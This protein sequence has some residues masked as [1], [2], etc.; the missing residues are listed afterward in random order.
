MTGAA[1]AG[2][3][4][5]PWH[6]LGD[7]LGEAFQ[8]ADD[9]RDALASSDEIGKPVGRD[10]V[11]GRPSAVQQHGVA[12]AALRLKQLIHGAVESIPDCPGAAQLRTLIVDQAGGFLPA[13]L[14]RRAA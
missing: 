9:L 5:Q 2:F 12:G 14:A 11:L 3:D 6:A 8:V 10:A 7:R 4:P 1:A 13:K